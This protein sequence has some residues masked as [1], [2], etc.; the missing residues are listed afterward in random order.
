MVP[1]VI[2]ILHSL[3]PMVI[4]DIGCHLMATQMATKLTLD[5]KTMCHLM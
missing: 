3:V 2:I 4:F 1:V 5:W